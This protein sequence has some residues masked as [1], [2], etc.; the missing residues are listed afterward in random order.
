MSSF[1]VNISGLHSNRSDLVIVG[2][3][4]IFSKA[5]LESVKKNICGSISQPGY[6]EIQ[7]SLNNIS[8]SISNQLEHVQR[9]STG[10]KQIADKY[11]STEQSIVNDIGVAQPVSL[12]DGFI[13]ATG[14]Q[15]DSLVKQLQR[16]LSGDTALLG[17][18]V[19]GS[20]GAGFLG[21]EISGK[22]VFGIENKDGKSDVGVFAEGSE[23]G[24]L[25]EGHGNLKVG[26]SE[27][28]GSVK[29]GTGGVSG[30]LGLALV[31]DGKISPQIVAKA[32]AEIAAISGK[33]ENKIG[34]DDYN[35]HTGIEGKVLAAE[36]KAEAGIGVVTITD[37]NGKEVTGIGAQAE[38]GAEA[39]VV[40]GEVSQGFTIAGIKF[41]FGAEGK[42]LSAGA[43]AGVKMNTG[44]INGNLGASL[45]LG[46]GL[47]FS[48][49]WT[50]FHFP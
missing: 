7:K 22:T 5:R 6:N 37:D 35:Y 15:V 26:I 27:T 41:D 16:G 33:A 30:A 47:K 28:T 44:G 42:V 39:Y 38:V 25:A 36:A 9:L 11:V 45:G 2:R 34:S 48:V 17:V 1:K 46:V 24:Y 10:L 50:G 43:H 13:P 40:K 21:T 49:D 32:K 23:T 3:K 31:K 12:A 19:S 20:I 14:W 29:L 8:E 4:L 18:P